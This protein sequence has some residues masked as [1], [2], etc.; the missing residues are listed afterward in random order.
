MEKENGENDFR[1]CGKCIPKC[2]NNLHLLRR[3]HLSWA[4]NGLTKS[5]KILHITERGLLNP[6]CVHRVQ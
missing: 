2:C 1:L 3:K 4:V 6:N 5:P